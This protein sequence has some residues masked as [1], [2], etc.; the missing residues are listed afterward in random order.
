M[1]VPEV[2]TRER[3]IALY[4]YRDKISAPINMIEARFSK[5]FLDGGTFYIRSRPGKNSDH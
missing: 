4:M 2:D 3:K 5:P 1:R